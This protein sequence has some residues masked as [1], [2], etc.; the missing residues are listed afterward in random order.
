MTS[1]LPLCTSAPL[2]IYAFE[3]DPE[4]IERLVQQLRPSLEQVR[5]ELLAFADFLERVGGGI[6]VQCASAPMVFAIG[7]LGRSNR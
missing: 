5:A 3:F 7:D 1:P 6:D 2:H 4:R